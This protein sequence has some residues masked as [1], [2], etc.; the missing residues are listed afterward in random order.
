MFG[1]DEDLEPEQRQAWIAFGRAYAYVSA[2]M[3]TDLMELHRLPLAWYEVLAQLAEAEGH[4]LRMVHLA[5]R[6][7]R[8]P[9]SLSRLVDRM[10]KAGL[11]R[12]VPVERDARGFYA[13]L[14]DAGRARLEEAAATYDRGVLDYVV[15]LFDDQELAQFTSFLDRLYEHPRT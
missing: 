7:M 13:V 12:R 10:I 15:R 1:P 6:L 2:Q 11:L 9:S 8:S 4:R 14:A 3:E 5:D